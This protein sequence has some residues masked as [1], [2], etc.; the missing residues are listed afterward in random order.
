MGA[1]LRRREQQDGGLFFSFNTPLPSPETSELTLLRF[2]LKSLLAA[3]LA[4]CLRPSNKTF[5]VFLP[6]LSSAVMRFFL[7]FFFYMDPYGRL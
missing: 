1:G 7:L 6:E 3:H 4:L 2:T 5:F